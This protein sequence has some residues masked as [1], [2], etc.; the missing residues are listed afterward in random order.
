[1][2]AAQRAVDG[3]RATYTLAEEDFARYQ[4]LFEDGSVSQRKYQEATKGFKTAKADVL[5]AEAKLAQAE[6]NRKQASIA[7]QQLRATKHAVAEATAA[8]ALAKVGNLQIFAAKQLLAERSRQVAEARR[9]VELAQ[10]NLDYTKVVAPYDAVIA[11]KW[12]HL[13]DYARTGD[14]IFSM[15]NPELLYVT[16][17]LEETLLPGVNPGNYADLNFDAFREPFRGRVVWIGSATGANFSLIPRD[18]SSGEFTYVVQR[19]PTRILI[20]PDER[21]PQLKPGLSVTAAIEHGSGDRPGP[22]RRTAN[23]P[24]LWGSRSTSRDGRKTGR[25]AWFRSP[26]PR[27]GAA[28]RGPGSRR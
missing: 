2:T 4:S 21:W 5:I 11:K 14:P 7:G 16:V 26:P 1:V 22:P 6:A 15:Y 10:V 17:N 23:L 20:E 24:G 8:V 19:V 25:S 28:G 3:T 12:R 13:G 18:I 9:A 27:P